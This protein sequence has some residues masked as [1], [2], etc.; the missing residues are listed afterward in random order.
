MS[1]GRGG[2]IMDRISVSKLAV[3]FERNAARFRTM[4]PPRRSRAAM[5]EKASRV[6][7]PGVLSRDGVQT[8]AGRARRALRAEVRPLSAWGTQAPPGREL[9]RVPPHRPAFQA[10]RHGQL[11]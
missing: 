5:I 7:S 6:R 2:G 3:D 8:L 10:G 4:Q 1:G 9:G 11:S